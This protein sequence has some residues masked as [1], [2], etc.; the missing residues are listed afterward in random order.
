MKTYFD[1]SPGPEGRV[2]ADGDEALAQAQPT[3]LRIKLDRADEADH[4]G[5]QGD[6]EDREPFGIGRKG[7]SYDL[8]GGRGTE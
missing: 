6:V 8:C 4:D 1:P 5:R 7:G 3:G 2:A